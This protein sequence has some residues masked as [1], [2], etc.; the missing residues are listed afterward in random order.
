VAAC[1]NPAAIGGGEAELHSYFPANA[2][3]SIL[4]SLGAQTKGKTW[5]SGAAAK[6]IKTPYVSLPGLVT[7]EC[8]STNGFHYL[9]ITVHPDPGPRADDVT[10]DLTPQWGLH[11]IDVNLVMGD[12]VSDVKAQAKAYAG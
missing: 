6:Q 8:A 1:A 7:G 12:L 2:G 9:S 5:V 4:A 10:G 11:L 3:A